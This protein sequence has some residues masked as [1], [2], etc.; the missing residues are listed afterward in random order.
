[1]TNFSLYEKK[2]KSGLEILGGCMVAILVVVVSIILYAA[3]GM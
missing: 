1:M 2:K 3:I